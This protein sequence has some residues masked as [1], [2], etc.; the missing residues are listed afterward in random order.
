MQQHQ[1]ENN[2]CLSKEIANLDDTAFEQLTDYIYSPY[3]VK[4]FAEQKYV[5]LYEAKG[6]QVL[7]DKKSIGNV[8]YSRKKW[9][10]KLW[11]IEALKYFPDNEK[12]Q[13]FSL[14][15]K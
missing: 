14:N 15:N 11:L 6:Y 3:D 4:E 13:N 10:K 5:N 12:L 9:S 2:P 7:N 1:S 8:G